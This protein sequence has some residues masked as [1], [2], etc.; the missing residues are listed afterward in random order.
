MTTKRV[1]FNNIVQ[2]QLPGYVK[3]DYPLVAE[4]LKSYYQGQEYEGGPID[5]VQNIDQYVKADNLTNLTYSVGL[6]ATVGISSDAIDVDMQN[7]PT[8][9]LVFPDSYG[10]LKINDE[11]ITYT[12]ITTFGFTGCIRGFSG[13][14]SYKLSLIHI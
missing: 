3:S 12:G 8:G 2:N 9:T 7:F 14:T 11:I 10:L 1:Q 6:G 13:I 5:L 4:F